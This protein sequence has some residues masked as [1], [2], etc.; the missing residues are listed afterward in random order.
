MDIEPIIFMDR[1]NNLGR[2]SKTVEPQVWQAWLDFC[3]YHRVMNDKTDD[4]LNPGQ[5]IMCGCLQSIQS[6]PHWPPSTIPE[7]FDMLERQ[8]QNDNDHHRHLATWWSEYVQRNRLSCESDN[9]IEDI[10]KASGIY[11]S[12]LDMCPAISKDMMDERFRDLK[13]DGVNSEYI[14][15]QGECLCEHEHCKDE[16]SENNEDDLYPDWLQAILDQGL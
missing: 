1:T 16:Y 5:G 14:R 10:W 2:F 9:I 11:L 8:I 12:I 13:L 3:Y 4:M 6:Y 7:A 15:H